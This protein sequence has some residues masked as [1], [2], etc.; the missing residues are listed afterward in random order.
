MML[1][2]SPSEESI[3]AELRRLGGN[4]VGALRVI[5]KRPERQKAG[6]IFKHQLYSV[7]KT[8]NRGLEKVMQTLSTNPDP[9][10]GSP[11]PDPAMAGGLSSQTNRQ[12]ATS[13]ASAAGVKPKE[14]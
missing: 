7:L 12:T 10:E 3:S 11:S 6:Q 1:N 13:P 2:A 14:R 9:D 8:S 5:W 4:V